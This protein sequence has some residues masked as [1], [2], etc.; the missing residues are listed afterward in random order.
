MIRQDEILLL[1]QLQAAAYDA[2]ERASAYR[3]QFFE[4]LEAGE[5]IEVGLHRVWIETY[6]RPYQPPAV[7][8]ELRWE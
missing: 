4:R 1:L 6:A 7:I 8:R 3:E 2:E 5:A